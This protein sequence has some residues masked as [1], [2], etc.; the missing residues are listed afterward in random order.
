MS[1]IVKKFFEGILSAFFVLAVS[2]LVPSQ[3]FALA[4]SII[5]PDSQQIAFPGQEQSYSVTFRGNGE[6]VVTARVVF[7]NDS[8]TPLSSLR[9]RT[10]RVDPKDILAFQVFREKICSRY[11]PA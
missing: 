8:R 10:P 2:L 7:F 4:Q 3:T 5:V 1:F 11:Q 9:L 6:A